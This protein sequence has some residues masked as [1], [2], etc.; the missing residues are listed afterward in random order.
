MRLA[1]RRRIRSGRVQSVPGPA[2][3]FHYSF[4][5]GVMHLINVPRRRISL[6]KKA[7]ERSW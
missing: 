7:S 5:E 3:R 2:R 6:P 4:T 1:A